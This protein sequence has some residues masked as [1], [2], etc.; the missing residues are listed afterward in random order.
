MGR[1]ALVQVQKKSIVV[2]RVY[3]LCGILTNL[4]A[5][6]RLADVTTAQNSRKLD[7]YEMQWWLHNKIKQRCNEIRGSG[8]REEEKIKMYRN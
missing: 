5:I 1:L 7:G 8:R 3:T 4:T 6:M 2:H